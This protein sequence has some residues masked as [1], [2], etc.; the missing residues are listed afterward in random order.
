VDEEGY[1]YVAGGADTPYFFGVQLEQYVFYPTHDFL[2]KFS[3]NGSLEWIRASATSAYYSRIA[4]I[5]FDKQG[6]I[7]IGGDFHTSI[8]MGSFSLNN[9]IGDNF[10]NFFI[11]GISP[12]GSVLWLKG[13]TGEGYAYMQDIET[14]DEGSIYFCGGFHGDTTFD[15]VTLSTSQ[16]GEYDFILIKL[17]SDLQ[18]EWVKF[19]DAVGFNLGGYLARSSD[20]VLVSGVE[21]GGF[22]LDNKS[23]PNSSNQQ[24]F[25]AAIS[26]NGTTSWLKSFGDALVSGSYSES[27]G[28]F[29]KPGYQ[30]TKISNHCFF[31]SGNFVNT[32]DTSDGILFSKSRDAFTGILTDVVD[33][34]VKSLGADTL[35]TLCN[36]DSYTISLNSNLG[37]NYFAPVHG[38]MPSV[39]WISS[40]ELS[41]TNINHGITQFKWIVKNCTSTSTKLITIN[42]LTAP[43]DPQVSNPIQF[44]SSQLPQA[45]VTIKGD[46]I[47][48]YRDP[49][50]TTAINA[51]N[52]FVPTISETLYV[53]SGTIGCTSKSAKVIISIIDNPPPPVASPIRACIGKDIILTATGKNLSWYTPGTSQAIYVGNGLKQSFSTSGLYQR[54]V[55]QTINGCESNQ[56]QLMINVEEF[57]MEDIFI[58]NIITP[59]GDQ[60]NDEFYLQPFWSE[61]C[62]GGF[63]SVVILNRWGERIFYST[64]RNFRW[65]GGEQIGVCYYVIEFESKNF[66]GPV[67][68]A[69]QG[70]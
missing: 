23:L 2:L 43:E 36:T 4:A 54:G 67:T 33:T 50:L 70:Q 7:I 60:L 11:A 39:S 31:V 44:C 37:T 28:F 34:P 48:W 56:A 9:P 51:G 41:L 27:N 25:V 69:R 68:V 55:S 13:F 10:S 59:N 53:T 1:S 14:D 38:A 64:D 49:L 18:V 17:S 66:N 8:A 62:I 22:E 30:L 32:L 57:S 3:P 24:A 16:Y 45:V 6:N 5:R 52:S 63:K 35:V 65:N 21:I 29:F 20:G 46:D 40:S 47:T 58:S 61:E 42:R 12:A 15:N 19:K 26:S